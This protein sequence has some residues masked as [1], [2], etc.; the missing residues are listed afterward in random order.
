MKPLWA[1]PSTTTLSAGGKTKS[2]ACNNG[3]GGFEGHTSKSK[4]P[5]FFRKV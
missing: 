4:R 1:S 3:A 5:L 2:V